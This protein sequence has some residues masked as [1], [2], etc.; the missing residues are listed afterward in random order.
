MERFQK[1][2]V[3]VDLCDT[4]SS[5]GNDLSPSTRS[6][7]DKA[8]W[9][10]E[11]SSAE[12]TFLSSLTP[13]LDA[14]LSI[15]QAAFPHRYRTMIDSAQQHARERVA[16]LVTALVAESQAAGIRASEVRV[17]GTPWV[18]L[19]REAVTGNH[20]LVIVGSHKQHA[21]GRLLL[22]NTGRRLVRKCPCP[23]WVTSPVKGGQVRRILVPTDFSDTAG[24]SLRLAHTLARQCNAELHVLHAVE[25]HF[26]PQMRELIVPAADVEEFRRHCRAE[27]ERVLHNAISGHGLDQSINLKHRHISAG[28][29]NVVI[30]DA[31]EKLSIDLVVMATL[32]RSGISGMV[33]GNTAEQVLAHLTCSLLAIKPAGFQ[34]P[35]SFSKSCSTSDDSS[36]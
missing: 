15:W 30:R 9:L 35:I 36:D 34:C 26:E 17:A 2:L 14:P 23:V 6:A 24:E 5:S 20:D 1:I 18:E 3:G 11:R 28:P 16:A 33:I 29:P 4:S 31:V 13:H 7:V 22:G 27:A 10:A 8:L 19:I 32:G 25:Y 12:V 21:V